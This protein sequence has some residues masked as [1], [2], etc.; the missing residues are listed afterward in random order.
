MASNLDPDL[1]EDPRESIDPTLDQLRSNK[2]HLSSIENGRG[3][4]TIETL[5]RMARALGKELRLDLTD[6]VISPSEKLRH[7]VISRLRTLEDKQLG[8]VLAFLLSEYGP[9]PPLVRKTRK[10]P[11]HRAEGRKPKAT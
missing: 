4:P 9:E 5:E 1:M 11:R 2:G 8:E 7:A 3:N 6:L 10:R